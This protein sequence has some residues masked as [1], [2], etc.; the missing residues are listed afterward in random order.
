M[1]RQT[2]TEAH[3]PDIPPPP[4]E[5]EFPPQPPAPEIE[6]PAPDVIPGPG[7]DPVREP[8]SPVDRPPL[9][10]T[11]RDRP[12]TLISACARALATD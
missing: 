12:H 7:P 11:P 8:P 4:A 5:P 6:P 1:T 3:R 2:L 10:A 9:V